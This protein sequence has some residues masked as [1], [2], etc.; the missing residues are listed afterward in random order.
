[1]I[2]KLPSNIHYMD[3]D[4]SNSKFVDGT[5]LVNGKELIRCSLE[6]CLK[7]WVL[8]CQLQFRSNIPRAKFFDEYES[9]AFPEEMSN[10][11]GL[12]DDPNA[13]EF[14]DIK[15]LANRTETFFKDFGI[16]NGRIFF[17]SREGSVVLIN[18]GNWNQHEIS[19]SMA[20][21]DYFISRTYIQLSNFYID[22]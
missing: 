1:M 12:Y 20:Y 19:N 11:T 6:F 13:M 4:Y 22:G 9:I 5:F 8:T 10:G 14:T 7:T 2:R 16:L 21:D 18:D 17:M 3:A 15:S